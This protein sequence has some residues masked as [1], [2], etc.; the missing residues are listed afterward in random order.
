MSTFTPIN[1]V[2]KKFHVRR[3][4]LKIRSILKTG[5]VTDVDQVTMPSVG[6][7]DEANNMG[8]SFYPVLVISKFN[9]RSLMTVELL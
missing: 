8:A 3:A 7:T 6:K 9:F 4:E 2:I 5:L 1:S